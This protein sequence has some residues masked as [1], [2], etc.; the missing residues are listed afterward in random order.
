MRCPKVS[1]IVVIVPHA[2]CREAAPKR[3]TSSP[4]PSTSGPKRR[5]GSFSP[6]S[7]LVPAC[8]RSTG[9]GSC[10]LVERACTPRG[11]D[12]ATAGASSVP[13]MAC[14]SLRFA[15]RRTLQV[16]VYRVLECALQLFDTRALEGD[17]VPKIDHLTVEQTSLV[18]E[19]NV[20]RVSFVLQHNS[21]R[22]FRPL[23][24][25]FF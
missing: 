25:T 7:P 15:P 14:Q 18:V 23:V 21:T 12:A 19:R 5:S 20:P 2:L 11:A 3:P 16:I 6:S 1:Q 9:S 10:L 22:L 4:P 24:H 17:H 13:R 8:Q